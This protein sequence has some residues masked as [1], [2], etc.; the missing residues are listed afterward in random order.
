MAWE[1]I[2]RWKIGEEI[3]EESIDWG[4]GER[5]IEG[6]ESI[7]NWT[8]TDYIYEAH[9]VRLQRDYRFWYENDN[10]DTAWK[11]T[12]QIENINQ[13]L[14][15]VFDCY[16]SMQIAIE[17][18]RIDILETEKQR[19]IFIEEKEDAEKICSLLTAVHEYVNSLVVGENVIQED[20]GE[21]VRGELAVLSDEYEGTSLGTV[22][23][24]IAHWME[25]ISTLSDIT[26]HELDVYKK[27]LNK[28]I[29]KIPQQYSSESKERYK[30]FKNIWKRYF[31]DQEDVFF[32]LRLMSIS[33]SRFDNE[34]DDV[35]EKIV[36]K[37]QNV[38]GV[39]ISFEEIVEERYA[40][41]LTR[42]EDFLKQQKGKN[43]NSKVIK[44]Y[45]DGPSC[46]GIMETSTNNY[47]ALSAKNDYVGG[48]WNAVLGLDT[49]LE[50]VA[51]MI[52]R[53]LFDNRYIWAQMIDE[54]RRY[55]D[56]VFDNK[57]IVKIKDSDNLANDF[58]KTSDG[59]VV[60]RTYGCC[61]RKMQAANGHNFSTDKL[62]Y[63][64]WAPCEKCVPALALERGKIRI[65]SLARDFREWR[66]M[67]KG[68]VKE[69]VQE[70]EIRPNLYRIK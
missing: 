19:R 13:V 37:V 40:E 35:I 27:D 6:D 33:K 61:E 21:D 25:R 53:E 15:N 58:G 64:R 26:L 20:S 3:I 32:R 4:L 28:L 69:G 34:I 5:D 60:G 51:N 54:T 12:F 52:N 8:I 57:N 59:N 56:L 1:R 65:F 23:S 22:L 38:Q 47:F 68:N 43:A 62:F 31:S 46:F 18:A 67:K 2:F 16:I 42:I 10:A 55:T 36:S 39:S 11:K 45:V 70:Y 9:T 7:F 41:K 30:L 14:H 49:T 29:D 66:E 48:V 24:D 44:K 63:A 17:I 50:E